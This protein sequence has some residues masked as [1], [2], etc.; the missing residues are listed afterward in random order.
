MATKSVAVGDY[1]IT[2]SIGLPTPVSPAV[3]PPTTKAVIHCCWFVPCSNATH[4]QTLVEQSPVVMVLLDRAPAKIWAC[5]E[6]GPCTPRQIMETWQKKTRETSNTYLGWLIIPQWDEIAHL[7][8]SHTMK[9]SSPCIHADLMRLKE[10]ILFYEQIWHWRGS[11]VF[12]YICAEFE[13]W[14]QWRDQIINTCL[15]YPGLIVT[16]NLNASGP[17]GLEKSWSPQ[18]PPGMPPYFAPSAYSTCSTIWRI[19]EVLTATA[20]SFLG[21]E[22]QKKTVNQSML[23]SP[24][25]IWQDGPTISSVLGHIAINI[26]E[27]PILFLVRSSAT[28]NYAKNGE[29]IQ[30][31]MLHQM[32]SEIKM[33]TTTMIAR[34]EDKTT[35]YIPNKIITNI[36]PSEEKT[37]TVHFRFCYSET[38]FRITEKNGQHLGN[39]S[40]ENA[41]SPH[42]TSA[43]VSAFD[44]KLI[45]RVMDEVA[46]WTESYSASMLISDMACT[47]FPEPNLLYEASFYNLSTYTQEHP[48]N[49]MQQRLTA[50]FNNLTIGHPNL[51]GDPW[52]RHDEGLA[53]FPLLKPAV[54]QL[55]ESEPVPNAPEFKYS[56]LDYLTYLLPET[57][58]GHRIVLE[59]QVA[60]NIVPLCLVPLPMGASGNP[61]R[62][63]GLYWME[64]DREIKTDVTMYKYEVRLFVAPGLD[65][66]VAKIFCTP[67]ERF[68]LRLIVTFQ[69]SRV[70]IAMVSLY[71]T[72][73]EGL[74]GSQDISVFFPPSFD[75]ST[76]TWGLATTACFAQYINQ[77]PITI[78]RPAQIMPHFY[79]ANVWNMRT[80]NLLG[81]SQI[82]SSHRNRYL[83]LP[84][85]IYGVITHQPQ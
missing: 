83:V 31:L 21:Y 26:A 76:G 77:T 22:N 35:K 18:S 10:I 29:T 14:D 12:M 43:G 15:E 80:T 2:L 78:T 67:V 61:A 63:L 44:P 65:S 3:F 64:V 49:F 41:I 1:T 81:S 37:V 66:I 36:L 17:F 50:S 33:V 6:P 39:L 5:V 16:N 19:D 46:W 25:L 7:L 38:L 57:T 32:G 84:A 24:K 71:D 53:A 52:A 42:Q 30:I 34:T 58:I 55:K 40:I 28:T 45:I 23:F 85:N 79:D 48:Q 68:R 75:F 74:E 13:A 59:C 56:D 9:S 11:P 82:G 47:C 69:G 8:V 51:F 27:S 4:L 62:C 72:P 54:T 70:M 73:P 60:P 20:M